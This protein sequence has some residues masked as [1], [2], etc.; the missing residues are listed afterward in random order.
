MIARGRWALLKP[1]PSFGLSDAE[2]SLAEEERIER[3]ARQYLHRYGIVF[4]ELLTRESEAPPYRELLRA[5][6]RLELRGEIRGGRLVQ[7][8]VGEQFAM[9]EALDTLRAL[10]REGQKGEIVRVSACDPLNLVG[11]IT[12]GSRVPAQLGNFVTYRDGVP[13]L[14]GYPGQPSPGLEAA[15]KLS[16]ITSRRP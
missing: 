7:G 6:R 5:Y 10:R 2:L 11:I 1:P 14:E 4:R 13:V 8:F 12:P 15:G 16:G 3:L 9:P